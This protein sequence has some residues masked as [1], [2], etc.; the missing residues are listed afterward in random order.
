MKKKQRFLKDLISVWQICDKKEKR[1]DFNVKTLRI[2]K[3]MENHENISMESL[4]E[5]TIGNKSDDDKRHKNSSKLSD[6]LRTF[7]HHESLSMLY[8][9]EVWNNIVVANDK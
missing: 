8:I 6:F 7:Q 9:D 1:Q 4:D 2:E 3:N 5:A